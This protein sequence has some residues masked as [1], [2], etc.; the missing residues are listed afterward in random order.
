MGPTAEVKS[1]GEVAP[2]VLYKF[3]ELC[4]RMGWSTTA[5]RSARRA[6]LRVKYL[7]G[8]AYCMGEEAIRYMNE[9]GKD[10]K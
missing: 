9:C 6:G 7:H 2:G 8:R 4:R 1:P 3:S 5:A 10:H